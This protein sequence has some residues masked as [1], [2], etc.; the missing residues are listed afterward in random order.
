MTETASSL[1]V[2]YRTVRFHKARIMAE[3]EITTN[4]ELVQYAVKN[5]II[6]SAW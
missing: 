5:G 6:S 2:T 4:A 3:V 1:G